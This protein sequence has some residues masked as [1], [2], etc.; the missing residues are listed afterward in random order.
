MIRK[1]IFFITWPLLF[2]S[3]FSAST[4][5]FLWEDLWLD[6]YKN[7]DEGFQELEIKQYQYELSGQSKEWAWRIMDHVNS[8]LIQN[9]IDCEIKTLEDIELI[10]NAG[11]EQIQAVYQKCKP[12]TAEGEIDTSKETSSGDLSTIYVS[13]VITQVEKVRVA[14]EQRAEEKSRQIYDIA[15]IGIY[16]DGVSENSPFDLITD[17]EEIDRVIFSEELEY[18]WE[19]YGTLDFSTELDDYTSGNDRIADAPYNNIA[20][21]QPGSETEE[22]LDPI[23]TGINPWESIA[24]IIETV[25]I[26][27]NPFIETEDGHLYA[28]YEDRDESWLSEV[29]LNW[30]ENNIYTSGSDIEPLAIRNSRSPGSL[31]DIDNRVLGRTGTPIESGNL[32]QKARFWPGGSHTKLYDNF[33]CDSF[34][35]ITVW[36]VTK[37]QS[38]FWVGWGWQTV[39]IESVLEKLD[40]HLDH[41]S[42][43][44]LVQAKMTTNNFENNL[45]IPN[46]W[47]MLR[48]FG[49]Q[50]QSKPTPILNIDNEESEERNG[51]RWGRFAGANMLK[52]YYKNLGLDYDRA[53]D[54]EIYT[55]KIAEIK[56]V[57]DS[58]E[59]PFLAVTDTLKEYEKFKE[60]MG[61]ENEIFSHALD[62]HMT[63]EDL[64]DFYNQFIELERF[65]ISINDF[66]ISVDGTVD[67]MLEIPTQKQ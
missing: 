45:I 40:G 6:L 54:L 22:T 47:D 58:A 24:E 12:E 8:I 27:W 14:L 63:Q 53:N 60:T 4:H 44:S 2:L 1:V 26:D 21:E 30:L 50:I 57:Q 13:N 55:D 67:K 11:P 16:S 17:I 52:E 51:I 33:N 32:K 66:A 37:S 5:A 43:T 35:C 28:C 39:S 20:E 3:I 23:A 29:S 42:S 9:G 7:I 41:I 62:N 10:A 56:A 59:L 18:I 65:A 34:F 15:R 61:K 48:G 64:G 25:D 36:L 19:D 46:L 49:I 31:W 38:L